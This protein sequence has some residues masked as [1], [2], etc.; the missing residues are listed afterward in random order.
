MRFPEGSRRGGATALMTA[1][2]VVLA[3]LTVGLGMRNYQQ[4][5]KVQRLS[6]MKET[7]TTELINASQSSP[8]DS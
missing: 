8:R 2:I 5:L 4:W 6:P 1:L 3:A 7:A